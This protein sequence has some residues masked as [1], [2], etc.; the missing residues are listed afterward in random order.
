MSFAKL[1]YEMIF[2]DELVSNIHDYPWSHDTCKALEREES[3]VHN[4]K[5][6]NIL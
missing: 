3:V 2:I 4:R 1:C 5:N 6:T